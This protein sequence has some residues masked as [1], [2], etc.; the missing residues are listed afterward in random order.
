MII[1]DLQ[2]AFDTIDYNI[3]LEKLQAI[4][5]CDDTVNWFLDKK[6]SI[7]FGEDK[8]KSIRFGTKRKLR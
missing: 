7:H 8:T 3:L 5:F 2:E 1:T 4:G 6:L